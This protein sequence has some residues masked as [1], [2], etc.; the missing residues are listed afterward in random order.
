MKPVII[1]GLFVTTKDVLTDTKIAAVY[2]QNTN[3]MRQKASFTL[4]KGRETGANRAARTLSPRPRSGFRD[5][6]SL[7]TS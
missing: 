3:L 5:F 1:W 4:V 7:R 2:I 6:S